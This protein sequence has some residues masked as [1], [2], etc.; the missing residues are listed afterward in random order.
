MH[1]MKDENDNVIIW[2]TNSDR[3]E[4]GKKY[5]MDATVK[6]HKMYKGIPQT[7]IT[8]PRSRQEV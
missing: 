2:W 1:Q 7:V 6:E 8:N 3:L 5:Q 4:E